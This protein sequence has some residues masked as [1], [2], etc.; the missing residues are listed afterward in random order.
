MAQTTSTHDKNG[1]LISGSTPFNPVFNGNRRSIAS[2]KSHYNRNGRFTPKPVGIP[3]QEQI[4]EFLA[5]FGIK[6]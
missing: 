2:P 1:K 4:N 6:K 5:S 3:S